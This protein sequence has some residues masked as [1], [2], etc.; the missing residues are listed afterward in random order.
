MDSDALRSDK[1]KNDI[2]ENELAKQDGTVCVLW[3]VCNMITNDVKDAASIKQYYCN[4]N[5]I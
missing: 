5:L 4:F 3:Y 1:H 2:N